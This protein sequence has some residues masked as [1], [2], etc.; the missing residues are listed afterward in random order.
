[1]PTIIVLSK[2]PFIRFLFICYLSIDSFL[3]F[4][5]V[6]PRTGWRMG[7]VSIAKNRRFGGKG[8]K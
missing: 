2:I 3:S 8:M 7:D 6:I 1:M 4:R 5:S